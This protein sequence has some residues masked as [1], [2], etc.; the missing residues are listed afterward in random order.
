MPQIV[1]VRHGQAS[2][3]G[4]DYDVLSELGVR[5]AQLA[6]EA[7]DARGITPTT[8]VSGSLRRQLGTAAAL[9]D[10]PAEPVVDARWN[11]YDSDDVLRAHGFPHGSLEHPEALTA[12]AG[13]DSRRF[14][15]VLDVALAAWID[16]GDDTTAAEPWPAFRERVTA[17]LGDVAGSLGS[18]ET[19]L[20]ATSGGVIATVAM[21]LLDAPPSQFLAFNRVTANAGFTKVVVGRSGTTLLS[22]NEH[23]HLDAAGAVTYR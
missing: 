18:G 8:V 22:F 9:L 10:A 4:D 13:A 23:A 16:A 1:L 2:F 7:L 19:A 15:D 6:R 14:Q 12:G 11:E 3:G 5:Q 17:A 20:V 21:H